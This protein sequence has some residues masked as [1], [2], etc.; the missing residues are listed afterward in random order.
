MGY[1]LTPLAKIHLK[2]IWAYTCDTWGE[3]QAMKYTSSI[4]DT[5]IYLGDNP[6]KGRK[7]DEIKTDLK[8]YRVE[9]HYIFYF[10]EAGLIKIVGI[11]HERMEPSRHLK[12]TGIH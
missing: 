2:Q 12:S 4:K 5:I 6:D 8:S 3:R 7:R 9:H 10:I 1:K 11:L